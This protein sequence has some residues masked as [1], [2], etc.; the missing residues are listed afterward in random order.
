MN[1]L[2]VVVLLAAAGCNAHLA[3]RGSVVMKV[4]D[5]DAHICMGRGE[6]KTGEEVHLYRNVCREGRGPAKVSDATNGSCRKEPAGNGKV[7]EVL[8]EHYSVVRFTPGTQFQE[9]DTVETG[10]R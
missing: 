2:L 6:V 9:G 3:M 5:T 10:R 1:R 7:T 8:N 4:S